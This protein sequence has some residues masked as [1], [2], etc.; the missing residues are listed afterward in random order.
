VDLPAALDPCTEKCLYIADKNPARAMQFRVRTTNR[1]SCGYCAVNG[2][3]QAGCHAT[4]HLCCVAG[5]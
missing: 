4:R 1:R 3:W 5:S 2:S